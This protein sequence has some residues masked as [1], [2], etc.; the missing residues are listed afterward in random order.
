M[1]VNVNLATQKFEVIR[2]F[3]RRATIAIGIAAAAFLVLLLF[4]IWNF[5][6]TSE[7]GKEIKQLEKQIA[8]LRQ[9]R[10]V[11][12]AIENRPDNRDV[13]E[14]K[15]FWN[16]QIA[17]RAFSWTQLFND[18]QRIMPKRAYLVSVAPEL[19]PD[20]K[21]KLKLTI[22]GERHDDALELQKHM[23][24]SER[25]RLPKIDEERPDAGRPGQPS[26]IWTFNIE[27]QYIPPAP[28]NMRVSR[29]EGM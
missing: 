10:A 1:R 13:T 15:N 3:L 25:F 2:L 23:E 12:E 22:K 21:V 20:N 26:G 27:T 29:K 7:S 8:Q 19:T 5:K 6:T 9:E 11:A 17:S 18:L 4:A 16:R 24:S 28:M 14:Q